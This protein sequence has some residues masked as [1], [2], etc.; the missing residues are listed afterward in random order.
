MNPWMFCSV[1]LHDV[2]VIVAIGFG[3]LHDALMLICSHMDVDEV[4]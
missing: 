2:F 4:R 1:R 3:F